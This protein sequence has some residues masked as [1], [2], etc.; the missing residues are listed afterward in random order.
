[1]AIEAERIAI[2]NEM[3]RRCSPMLH[4]KYNWAA[5]MDTL[6]RDGNRVLPVE[7]EGLVGPV[8]YVIVLTGHPNRAWVSLDYTVDA[9]A[10]IQNAE[11]PD[12]E[13]QVQ[14]VLVGAAEK[15]AAEAANQ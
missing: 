13:T 15:F 7:A 3:I 11:D 6:E 8:A 14:A 1:M 2:L 5:P 9:T 4:S 10:L 12:I